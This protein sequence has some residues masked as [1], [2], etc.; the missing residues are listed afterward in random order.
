MMPLAANASGLG[1]PVERPNVNLDSLI[2]GDEKSWRAV[3][4]AYDALVRVACRRVRLST[5]DREDAAQNAWL[6]A[7]RAIGRLRDLDKL[8]SWIY[9]IAYRA[10]LDV[11]TRRRPDLAADEPEREIGDVADDAPGVEDAITS[12]EDAHRLRSLVA[13]LD[14]R[15]RE[16]L[17]ALFLE[18]PRPSY[19]EI[20][21]RTEI[22]I[23][24][25]GPSRGRCLKKLEKRFAEVSPPPMRGS[26]SANDESAHARPRAAREPA[27]KEQT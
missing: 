26:T 13:S 23:G 5:D 3:V 2:A 16:L 24:S 6:S 15:C 14:P 1:G 20:V 22:P 27:A 11:A 9:S 8:P 10:A 7:F 18:D 12:L 21:A 19:E 25:I 17:A 4:E